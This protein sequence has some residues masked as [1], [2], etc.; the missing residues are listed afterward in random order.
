MVTATRMFLRFLIS[1]NRCAP[2]LDEAIPC[3]AERRLATLPQ[4]L[5]PESIEC[6]IANLDTATARGVRDKAIVLLL[7]RLGLRASEI[8]GLVF[9]DI[10]WQ[11]ATLSVT[12]KSRREA[13]L[14]LPQEVG[15]ALLD[16]LN[17]ARPPIGDEHIFISMVAPWSPI[18]RCVVHTAGTRA[19]LQ[20]GVET[21]ALGAHVYR[22]SAATAMLRQGASLPI[23]GEILRHRSIETTAQY[24]KVDVDR[25]RQITVPWHGV[26]L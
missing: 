18:S 1:V 22:H 3:V 9:N 24:A 4:Y 15:D 6:I 16:Y 10:N 26:M 19:I 14:P 2:G 12:G 23:V 25:L 17:T 20:A 8:A 13:R 5:S 7:A 11:H 21:P